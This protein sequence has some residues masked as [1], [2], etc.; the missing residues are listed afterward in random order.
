MTPSI[1]VHLVRGAIHL[2]PRLFEVPNSWLYITR[3]THWT[4]RSNGQE[5]LSVIAPIN[6]PGLER[7]WVYLA[8]MMRVDGALFDSVYKARPVWAP[9]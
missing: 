6:T 4:W 5:G 7:E 3:T 2:A 9:T 1:K 8:A